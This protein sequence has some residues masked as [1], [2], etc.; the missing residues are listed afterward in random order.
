MR[1][2]FLLLTALSLH[3]QIAVEIVFDQ[4]TYL[5]SESLVARV[6]ITNRSGGP[7][8]FGKGHDWLT[9]NIESAQ[10][11]IVSQTKP[12]DVEGEFTLQTSEVGTKRIDLAPYYTITT[13]GRYMASATVH[14]P[15]WNR[16]FSSKSRSFDIISG[17]KLMELPFGL[18][19]ASGAPEMRKYVLQQVTK[20]KEMKL[21]FR[22][23][24]E[25]GLHTYTVFPVAPM[26]TFSRPEA[27]I[28]EESNLHVLH[29]T[30]ARSFNYS[31]LDPHGKMILRQTY[32]YTESRPV[33]RVKA[34]GK[35][36][37]V[38]GVRRVAST[39]IPSANASAEKDA[40]TPATKN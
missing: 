5:S 3:A 15:E 13:P 2:L 32:D 20:L 7:I 37:V 23:T 12:L 30:G 22:L 29:Q 21:Y 1:F 8:R 26:V 4:E 40:Q 19:Q 36:G 33:L 25:T 38:G 6:R 31:I 17:T 35:L 24:D 11:F 27:Q 14:I 34:S 9:I 10:N 28:D 39:D 16:S 18:P